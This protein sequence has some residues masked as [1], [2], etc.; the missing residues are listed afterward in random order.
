MRFFFHFRGGYPVG[1]FFKGGEIFGGKFKGYENF[2]GNYKGYE[3]S[4]KSQLKPYY[5]PTPNIGE[6]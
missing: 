1:V 6:T 4:L 3:R 2:A 5:T